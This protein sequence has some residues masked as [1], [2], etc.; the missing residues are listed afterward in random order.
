MSWIF[1]STSEGEKRQAA[2]GRRIPRLVRAIRNR[3]ESP[4]LRSLPRLR[5]GQAGVHTPHARK[6]PG[7]LGRNDTLRVNA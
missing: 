5:S 4:P 6:K 2:E 1:E 3:R 7:H